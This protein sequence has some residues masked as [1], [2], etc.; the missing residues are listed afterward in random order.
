MASLGLR[1]NQDLA[2][3]LEAFVQSSST[4]KSYII[5]QALTLCM[6]WHP[7]SRSVAATWPS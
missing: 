7:M 2:F 5:L 6:P 1:L 3:D 4:S